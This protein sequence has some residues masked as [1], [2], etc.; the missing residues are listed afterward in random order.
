MNN[1][2]VLDLAGFQSNP[3]P[4]PPNTPPNTAWDGGCWDIIFTGDDPASRPDPITGQLWYGGNFY[5]LIPLV[6][7][8]LRH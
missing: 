4:P 5:G 1:A 6:P 2:S 8:G 3:N 7:G